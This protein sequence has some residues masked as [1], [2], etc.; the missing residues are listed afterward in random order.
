[1]SIKIISRG[2]KK[3]GQKTAQVIINNRTVHLIQHFPGGAYFDTK[4]SPHNIG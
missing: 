4:G 2:T 1:M 3:N